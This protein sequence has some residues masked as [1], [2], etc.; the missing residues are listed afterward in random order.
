MIQYHKYDL[1]F[2]PYQQIHVCID[3]LKK[4]QKPAWK[5]TNKMISSIPVAGLLTVYLAPN[6]GYSRSPRL[7]RVLS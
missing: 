2:T 7:S 3:V 1:G 5:T 6:T 4:T